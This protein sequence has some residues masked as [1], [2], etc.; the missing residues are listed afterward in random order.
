MED[1]Q[2]IVEELTDADIIEST[3]IPIVYPIRKEG[4]GLPPRMIWGDEKG[5]YHRE[6]GPAVIFDNGDQEWYLH[7]LQHRTGG[8]AIEKANG[9]KEWGQFGY[10]HRDDGPAIEYPNGEYKVWYKKGKKHRKD[11][12]AIEYADGRCE[13]W[14]NGELV[15]VKD[16][17]TFK[18]YIKL[19]AMW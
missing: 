8:P 19:N 3:L 5:R 18:K 2:E 13:W 16:L 7:G 10:L 1:T 11:G 4:D 6:D 9:H 15:P 12:P 14:Y 17:A